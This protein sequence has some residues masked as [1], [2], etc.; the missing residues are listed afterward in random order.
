MDRQVLG[1]YRKKDR[2]R[3]HTVIDREN[4]QDLQ[5]LEVATRRMAA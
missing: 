4:D 2:D 3:R 5:G 1:V